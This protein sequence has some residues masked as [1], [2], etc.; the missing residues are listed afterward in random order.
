MYHSG[1]VT[2]SRASAHLVAVFSDA[3]KC[4]GQIG[5]RSADGGASCLWWECRVSV[6]SKRRWWNGMKMTKSNYSNSTACLRQ[7]RKKFASYHQL[8]FSN[9]SLVRYENGCM[10]SYSGKDCSMGWI[11]LKK[12]KG[13]FRNRAGSYDRWLRLNCTVVHLILS[14][15]WKQWLNACEVPLS[16]II[17]ESPLT[18]GKTYEDM[19]RQRSL[20]NTD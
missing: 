4:A 2:G 6:R 14:V 18:P 16:Q 7:A 10:R 15:K 19:R 3:T 11:R 13:A 5:P 12:D 1:S 8:P 20:C 17:D 9:S